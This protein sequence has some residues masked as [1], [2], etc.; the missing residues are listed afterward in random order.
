MRKPR[1]K[2]K[3]K[4]QLF[5]DVLLAYYIVWLWSLL[6]LWISYCQS[7][8]FK[9][10][11]RSIMWLYLVMPHPWCEKL[12]CPFFFFFF[13]FHIGVIKFFFWCKKGVRFVGFYSSIYINIYIYIYILFVSCVIKVVVAF[14]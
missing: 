2:K 8:V 3:K 11:D 9:V 13:G 5:L 4:N 12:V 1:K 14:L 7:L 6:N 10:W